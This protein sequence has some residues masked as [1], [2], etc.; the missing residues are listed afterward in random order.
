M[1]ELEEAEIVEN[2]EG[3]DWLGGLLRVTIEGL[4]GFEAGKEVKGMDEVEGNRPG[5][6]SGGFRVTGESTTLNFF[7]A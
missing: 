2:V 7:D 4:E 1:D 6:I 5:K 3:V